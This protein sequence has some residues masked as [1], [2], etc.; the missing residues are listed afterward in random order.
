MPLSVSFHLYWMAQ[1]YDINLH[2]IRYAASFPFVVDVNFLH[3][4]LF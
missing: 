2:T 3:F 1:L 4:F